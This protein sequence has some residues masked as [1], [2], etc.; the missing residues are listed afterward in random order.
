MKIPCGVV[1][2]ALIKV[3]DFYYP[4]DFIILDMESPADS[5][6]QTLVILGRPFLAT[7]N[8][9]ID[10]R[11]GAIEI[12][13]GNMTM[14]MNI[15]PAGGGKT[16]DSSCNLIQDIDPEPSELFNFREMVRQAEQR[17]R[18][19]KQWG[20]HAYPIKKRRKR[21]RR[22]HPRRFNQSDQ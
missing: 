3:G 20:W 21:R 12:S 2:D 18:R 1:E 6:N 22:K 13:F 19:L 4:V 15:F 10:C 16:L 7:A 8:A 5:S 11:S 14:E 9:N 17:P